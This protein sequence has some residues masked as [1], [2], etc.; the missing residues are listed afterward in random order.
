[1]KKPAYIMIIGA[2]IAIAAGVAAA[3]YS[4]GKPLIKEPTLTYVVGG[5]SSS[6]EEPVRG[7]SSTSRVE[8]TVDAFSM[9]LIHH[10]SYVCCADMVVDLEPMEP[11]EDYV[12]LRIIERNVG[13]M[14]RCICDYEIAIKVSDLGPGRYKVELYGIEYED[15]PAE[16]LWE[17]FIEL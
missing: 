17:N 14:C 9:N 13:E 5:C 2:L 7:Y 16:K 1:M 11:R 15:M 12:L 3:F 10:L 8:L 4:A 6:F